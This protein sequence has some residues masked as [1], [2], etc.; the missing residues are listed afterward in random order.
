MKSRFVSFESLAIVSW[1]LMIC[2]MTLGCAKGPLWRTGYIAPWAL[3][4]WSEEERIA[5]TLFS[6]R[7]DL[8]ASVAAVKGG[9]PTD[10][11]HIAQKL[12]QMV[13]TEPVLLLRIEAVK[14][15]GELDSPVAESSLLKASKDSN[16][17]VRL[18]AVHA[19]GAKANPAA[20]HV[21][22]EVVGADTDIDVRLAATREL[23]NFRGPGAVQALALAIED[24]DPALQVRAVDSLAVVTGQKFGGD[25]QAWRQFVKSELPTPSTEPSS[26]VR[27]ASGTDSELGVH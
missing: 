19:C 18:A 27:T 8:R 4:K 17:D 20:L 9:R 25:I 15:L 21:L 6:R 24:S 2:V 1:M 16:A 26:T 7:E 13:D 12:A 10:R 14:L 23:R 5:P 3:K 11:D 22:Q